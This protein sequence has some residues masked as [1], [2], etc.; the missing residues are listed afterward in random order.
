MLTPSGNYGFGSVYQ[1]FTEDV[2]SPFS[3]LKVDELKVEA[4][5]ETLV[6]PESGKA[7]NQ[8]V[9]KSTMALSLDIISLNISR[10]VSWS[11][12]PVGDQALENYLIGSLVTGEQNIQANKIIFSYTE[13]EGLSSDVVNM[14]NHVQ[15]DS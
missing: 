14:G 5:N 15:T 10:N 4:G 6:R 9:L 2:R 7:L 1:N 3:K 11:C 13:E 12:L 8:Y